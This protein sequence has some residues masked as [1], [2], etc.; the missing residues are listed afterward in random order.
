MLIILT[1]RRLF[2]DGLSCGRRTFAEQVKGL[3]AR[4]E[5]RSPILHHLV[6]MVGVAFVG[7]G[8]VRF[9]HIVKAPLSRTGVLFDLMRMRSQSASP[10]RVP[11]VTRQRSAPGR[12]TPATPAHCRTDPKL[13]SRRG[14]RPGP[15]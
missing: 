12:S 7:H 11:G 14:R 10:P 15:S 6:E 8:G 1:V 2:C 3:T 5:R 13:Q 4:C 9:L